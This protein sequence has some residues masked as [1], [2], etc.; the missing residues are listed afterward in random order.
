[1][2][3]LRTKPPGRTAA[4]ACALATG[5]AAALTGLQDA[6]ELL[7]TEVREHQR[8]ESPPDAAADLIGEH[9]RSSMRQVMVN[10]GDIEYVSY[11][12]VG[13]Q[14][15][16]G[17]LDTGSFELVVFSTECKTCGTAAKYN[18]KLSKT[19]KPGALM[20][21]QSYG[22]GDTYSWEAKDT[23]SIG[24]FDTKNQ[25]FWEVTDARMPIL[26]NAAFQAIIG[27]GPPETPAAD[28][29]TEVQKSLESVTKY[30]GESRR[31]P[32]DV[33]KD[34]KDAIESALEMSDTPPMLN[35]FD[36][37]A[38][39]ICMGARPASD[40]YFT[41]QERQHLE[42]PH[43]FTRVSILGK[44]T[45]SVAL[46]GVRLTRPGLFTEHKLGCFEEGGC[47][48]LVD[49]GTSLLAVPRP[50]IN[51]VQDIVSKMNVNCDDL[52]SLPNLVFEMGGKLL[53]LPP[54]AYVAVVE[55]KV[56][57][58]LA[59]F[60]RLRSLATNSTEGTQCNVLLMESYM[61]SKQGPV[62]IFGMPFFR[63]F[64]TTFAVGDSHDSRALYIAEANDD[65]RPSEGASLVRTRPHKRVI[66][67]S[68]VFLPPL[69]KKKTTGP[70][71]L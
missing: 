40:G 3:P 45:W 55:G 66:D 33:L 52:S 60:V 50:V 13:D 35:T 67:V 49:S 29:W 54:D 61:D 64:Y 41:W 4:L 28:A 21:V 23:V 18:P 57:D 12:K 11:L 14:T 44:H 2:A 24:P 36:V 15:I 5:R 30:Y 16:A 22:S 7:Q 9:S 63:K 20:T 17:I 42:K 1:M 48:A 8:S 34:V 43:L 27:I 62:W 26:R 46:T 6:L 56:P 25:T 71:D 65:C 31:P 68:K 37:K 19:H 38:F 59:S 58:H 53:S 47:S 10:I 70:V 39:S 32:H 69:L 51:K